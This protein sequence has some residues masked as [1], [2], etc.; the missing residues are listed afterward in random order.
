VIQFFDF[1]GDALTAASVE[2]ISIPKIDQLCIAI[3]VTN[4]SDEDMMLLDSVGHS[5]CAVL[6]IRMEADQHWSETILKQVG[7]SSRKDEMGRH[8]IVNSIH[9]FIQTA[10]IT[11]SSE[12]KSWFKSFPE[13]RIELISYLLQSAVECDTLRSIYDTWTEKSEV[14]QVK[15]GNIQRL[16]REIDDQP[17][18]FAM[19]VPSFRTDRVLHMFKLMH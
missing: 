6:Q 7:S 8:N 15:G 17:D 5:L 19:Q 12:P 1:F 9:D 10:Q 14:L 3:S 13:F 16:I 4:I 18:E 2:N 11:N